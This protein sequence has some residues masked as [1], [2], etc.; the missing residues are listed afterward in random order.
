PSP[1]RDSLQ[2]GSFSWGSAMRTFARAFALAAAVLLPTAAL[3]A[4]PIPPSPCSATEK[5]NPVVVTWTLVADATEY[6]IYRT[7]SL[8]P[9]LLLGTVP[10]GTKSF[11]DTNPEPGKIFDYCV[12]AANP[13][14][15]SDSCCSQV[16]TCRPRSHRASSP[17]RAFRTR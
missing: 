13:D 2:P 1:T 15:V 9:T 8:E 10:Q 17:P 12:V 3:A 16:G 4:T 7:G 11:E 5:G 14:G 6:K